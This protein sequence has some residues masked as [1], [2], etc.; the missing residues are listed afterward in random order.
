MIL[1]ASYIYFTFLLFLVFIDDLPV[2][3]VLLVLY[4]IMMGC[5]VAVF[6]LRS[7]WEYVWWFFIYFVAGLPVFYLI[8]PLWSFWN[9]DDFSWG[10]TRAVTGSGAVGN[11]Q[12]ENEDEDED[13]GKFHKGYA[14][15]DTDETSAIP[16]VVQD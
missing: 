4:A 13:D 11:A 2:S 14:S 1:P 9:M 6:V 16:S 15:L 7:R 5:Q 3:T 8:L 10:K 12:D